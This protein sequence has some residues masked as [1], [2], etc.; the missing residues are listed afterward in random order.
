MA[1]DP[2]FVRFALD[3]HGVDGVSPACILLQDRCG[4][5]VNVLLAAAYVGAARGSAFTGHELEGARSRTLQWHHEVVRP[6]RA[7]RR[8]LV[9]GPSPAPN[10]ATTTLR[11]RVKAVELDAE[12]IE[13]DELAR[14]VAG[15]DASA[16]PGTADERATAAMHVV[17]RESAGREPG[18]DE[19]TAIAV[20]AAAAARFGKE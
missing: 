13:L 16:A 2:D 7:L 8:R 6:L 19:H 11:E 15:V 1:A 3:V 14:F 4:L 18:E 17:V 10:P 9:D 20:I 5:D 12:M